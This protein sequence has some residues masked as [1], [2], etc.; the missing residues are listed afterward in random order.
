L[1]LGSAG[2]SAAASAGAGWADA[3]RPAATASHAQ[4]A[5]TIAARPVAVVGTP[6]DIL[7]P[8]YRSGSHD[9]GKERGRAIDPGGII[10]AVAAFPAG[11][12]LVRIAAGGST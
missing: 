8:T 6:I 7:V 10:R 4:T 1:P 3:L 2:W 9:P 5:A 12:R 11:P